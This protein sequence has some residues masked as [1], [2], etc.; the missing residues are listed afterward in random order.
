MGVTTRGYRGDHVG[1]S[2]GL[3]QVRTLEE[4]GS[5]WGSEIVG[6]SRP[7]KS[8]R[9]CVS[10][11]ASWMLEKWGSGGIMREVPKLGRRPCGGQGH[12]K[13][14][15]HTWTRWSVWFRMA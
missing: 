8:C 13:G 10:K 15:G 1:T 2:W 6:F 14:T 3:R 5:G 4:L 12:R 9:R 7:S 11:N